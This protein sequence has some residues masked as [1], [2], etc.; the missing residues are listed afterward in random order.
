[1][2]WVARVGGGS[3]L[4]DFLALHTEILDTRGRCRR[5]GPALRWRFF[6]VCTRRGVLFQ[7]KTSLFK[8]PDSFHVSDVV[9]HW[10]PRLD[11]QDVM[12][13]MEAAVAIL[14]PASGFYKAQR[15]KIAN[16]CSELF[17]NRC[18]HELDSV[19]MREDY[20]ARTVTTNLGVT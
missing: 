8:S 11:S 10:H 12:C 2:P 15:Q 6:F 3:E 1:M 17:L 4:I 9:L 20:K 16:D 13:E 18:F 5:T 19:K 7:Y 14:S